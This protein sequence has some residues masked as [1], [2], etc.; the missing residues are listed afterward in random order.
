MQY[1]FK[2]LSLYLDTVICLNFSMIFSQ[3]DYIFNCLLNSPTLNS[4]MTKM[5]ANSFLLHTVSFYPPCLPTMWKF[6]YATLTKPV[7]N[8]A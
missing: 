8:V 7:C 6:G 4:D 1:H 5:L 2:T 3:L